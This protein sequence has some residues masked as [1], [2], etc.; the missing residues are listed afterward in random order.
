M[1]Y[2]DKY[3]EDLEEPKQPD[4]PKYMEGWNAAVEEIDEE[5]RGW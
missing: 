3:D 5:S 4:N 1:D 2:S